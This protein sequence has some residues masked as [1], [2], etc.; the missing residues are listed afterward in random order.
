MA[1]GYR[2]GRPGG[3]LLLT[4]AGYRVC[5]EPV[6]WQYMCGRPVG[7][8]S[9]YGRPVGLQHV[10]GR[11]VGLQSICGRPVGMHNIGMPPAEGMTEGWLAL[12]VTGHRVSLPLR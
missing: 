6:G 9:V 5:G 8:H 10:R 2:G 7:L 11:P 4:Q 12:I 3:L 1:A